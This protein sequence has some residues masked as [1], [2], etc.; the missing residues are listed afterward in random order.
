MVS[1]DVA[2]TFNIEVVSIFAMKISFPESY[3]DLKNIMSPEG[4]ESEWLDRV[5]QKPTAW[6]GTCSAVHC[7]FLLFPPG[8]A[9]SGHC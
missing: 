3:V 2:I 5:T 6:A 7:D 1:G 4:M 9:D 8:T